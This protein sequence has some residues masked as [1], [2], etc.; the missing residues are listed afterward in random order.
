MNASTLRRFFLFSAICLTFPA[1]VIAAEKPLSLLAQEQFAFA[2]RQYSGLL[3]R[4][5][6]EPEKLPRTFVD[7]QLKTVSARDW[8]SGFFPGSLWF[9]YEHTGDAQ[10]KAAAENFTKRVESIKDFTG[11]HDIGFM[12]GCSYGQ[13]Y[14][15]TKE[16]AYRDVLVQGA[17]NL[18]KR[19]RPTV[20]L[21]KSWDAR[22]WQ[23]PV[24]ID[25][26]MNLELLLVAH[27]E[28]G[29]ATFR[30]IAVSHANLTLANHFRPDASSFHLLDYD[31]AS[32]AIL[33]RQTVQGYADDSAWARGQAWGLYGFTR[34]YALT[35]DPAYL[36]QARKI[37]D[38]IVNH[39][40]LPAD[41]IPYWDF[42]APR[43]P[44]ALRDSSAAAI[45]CCGLL[46]LAELVGGEAG[47][48]YRAVAERQLR[49][50]C[51]AAF[52]A[53]LDENGNFLLMHAVGHMPQKSEIDVPI[54][55]GDYYFLEA[56]ARYM[57][58]K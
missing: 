24:I 56:L 18:A 39:P 6:N 31:P 50:L 34:V 29:E 20:G 19:Y 4:L 36:A 17:R 57:P 42:D 15:L 58:K 3:E 41:G 54:V 9:I 28:T 45:T 53:G 16:P 43:S 25:N 32:G 30:D 49:T 26:M 35:K 2:A 10:F 7:G 40:R 37:A 55:Y 38:F 5:A 46:E 12:L 8:T 21:I 13:G 48:S 44:D 33:K 51:T 23:Y 11:H 1:M 52:R 14:R 22:E 47:N 27:A